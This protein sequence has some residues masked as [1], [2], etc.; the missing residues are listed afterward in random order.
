MNSTTPSAAAAFEKRHDHLVAV[1]SDG[2]AMDT[3]TFKHVHCFTPEI[4]RSFA[5]E[6]IAVLVEQTEHFVN[7]YSKWRGLNRFPAL[8]MV[9]DLL[10]E[11]P[12]VQASGVTIPAM[13]SLR[14]FIDSEHPKSNAGLETVMDTAG[15]NPELQ[16]VLQWSEAVNQAVDQKAGHLR[17]FPSVKPTLDRMAR[18]ADLIVV[19]QMPHEACRREWQQYSLVQ[20]VALLG[21]QELGTKAEQLR[22]A[23]DG[24]YEPANVLMVGDAPGDLT[25]AQSNDALFFPTVPGDEDGSWQQLRDEG[26]DRF[27]QSTFAGPYQQSLL[28][29]FQQRLPETPPWKA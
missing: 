13:D 8:L 26:F 19:S 4:I 24:R 22:A 16:R 20:H 23:A 27:L 5:L 7:L 6:P 29:R 2:C 9:L 18:Q 1:D 25:A 12:E 21:G 14:A 15:P 28:E 17:P 3:M 11:R 10:R